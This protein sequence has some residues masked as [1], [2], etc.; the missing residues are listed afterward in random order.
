[1]DVPIPNAA[2]NRL[3]RRVA[4]CALT[5]LVVAGVSIYLRKMRPAAP[6]VE[7]GALWIDTVKKGRLLREVR[8]AGTLVPEELRYLTAPYSG[9]VENVRLLPGVV[10]SED[11]ILVD[12][13]S[14]E[15]EQQETDAKIALRSGEL[16]LERFKAQIQGQRLDRRSALASMLTQY[17]N[18]RAKADR[19][20][21]MY[22]QG[23]ML[24]LD[25]NYSKASFEDT[26]TKYA[27][28]QEKSQSIEHQYDA[29]LAAKEESVAQLRNAVR[30][31]GEQ[32]A[33][34]KVRAG[35]AGVLQEVSAKAGQ[36]VGAGSNIATIVQP[37]KL[38]AELKVSETQA[39]DVRIGQTA[40][41]DTRNG[42]ISGR[43]SRIDPAVKDGAVTVDVRLQGQLPEGARP[44][45]SID[46]AI[47]IE[48]LENVTYIGKPA[49]IA[50]NGDT[51]LF[52]L[53]ADGKEANR[54]SITLG[55]SSLNQ[56]EVV[57][58]V[59]PGESIVLSDMT[60]YDAYDRLRLK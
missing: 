3:I 49:N 6:S 16:E 23:L 37:R 50:E 31:R 35:V 32:L 42:I 7:K 15:L 56:V 20:E 59:R 14:P 25:Y 33:S 44:D 57:H 46:G 19:D 39:K 1:M 30:L 24:E 18:A 11:T 8:G 29:E 28:E 41:I 38:K 53:S 47:Q 5:L 60:Q 12:L 36:N 2:R 27:I 34:L 21:N 51:P 22:K 10:V 54:V 43:V 4:A 55:R 26:A 45:L 40:A 58:G 17:K 13:R 52:R 9:R 48:T